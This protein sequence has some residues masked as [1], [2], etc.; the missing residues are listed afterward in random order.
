MNLMNSKFEMFALIPKRL[1]LMQPQLKYN[2][3]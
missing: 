1:L 3:R 2:P